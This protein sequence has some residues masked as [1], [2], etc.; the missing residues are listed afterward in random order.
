VK[1]QED[2]MQ[3]Y[4][5]SY[6]AAKMVLRLIVLGFGGTA[7]GH[8]LTPGWGAGIGAVVGLLAVAALVARDSWNQRRGNDWVRKGRELGLKSVVSHRFPA[9]PFEGMNEPANLLSDSADGGDLFIG[10]R[11]ERVLVDRSGEYRSAYSFNHGFESYVSDPLMV[12][13]FFLLRVSGPDLP[14]L[15]A[16]RSRGL[17]GRGAED[18][19]PGLGLQGVAEWLAEHRQWQVELAGK[20]VLGFSP[21]VIFPV[22]RLAEVAEAARSLQQRLNS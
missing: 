2:G 1:I 6:H 4:R 18:E 17:W 21:R 8:A 19:L 10:D 15:S 22:S 12:E 13:T 7:V 11:M 16:G 5:Y 3:S 20:F 14:T 9:I